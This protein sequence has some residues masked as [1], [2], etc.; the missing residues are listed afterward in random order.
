MT[1]SRLVRFL[2]IAAVVLVGSLPVAA[3]AA[4]PVGKPIVVAPPKTLEAAVA[5][6][7]KATG[8][9]AEALEAAKGEVPRTEG[10]SFAVDA[11][12]AQRLLLGSHT[13]FRKAGFYLFRYERS[14]GLAG[15][16]DRLG[17]LTLTDQDAVIRLMGTAG[18]KRQITT[19]QIIAALDAIAKDAPF[20]LN[21]VGHDYV[22]GRFDRAPKD[23]KA[24]AVR[25]TE[26]APDLLAGN[27]DK[28][29][30][31][32]VEEIRTNRTLLLIWE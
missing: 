10:A 12:V 6:I 29:M 8:S 2:A 18:P 25:L 7:E 31:L 23:P 5:S 17:L 1:S 26:V 13:A 20:E 28:M 27:K 30:S 22:A 16:K 32:L 21:E 9:K 4:K 24:L 11:H 15:E 14:F 19:D 3:H